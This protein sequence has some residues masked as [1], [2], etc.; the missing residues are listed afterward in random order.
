MEGIRQLKLIEPTKSKEIIKE[1][2]KIESPLTA[3]PSSSSLMGDLMSVLRD[4]RMRGFYAEFLNEL[5]EANELYFCET[6]QEF[7]GLTGSSSTLH[8]RLILEK[9]ITDYAEEPIDI[10][11]ETRDRIVERFAQNSGNP[12]TDLFEAAVKECIDFMLQNSFQDFKTSE[13]YLFMQASRL[14]F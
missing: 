7:E 9:Y 10:Q 13:R 12:P 6:V 8:A 14:K 11:D 5:G 2:K 3:S 4:A 1:E